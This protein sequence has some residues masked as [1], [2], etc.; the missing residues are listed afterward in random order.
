MRPNAQA[1]AYPYGREGLMPH[2]CECCWLQFERDFLRVSG[3]GRKAKL[4][5]DDCVVECEWDLA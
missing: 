4:I 5:C 1:L 2:W 3:E